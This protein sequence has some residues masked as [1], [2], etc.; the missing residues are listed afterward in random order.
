MDLYQQMK[1]LLQEMLLQLASLIHQGKDALMDSWRR[2]A[3]KVL[4][5]VPALGVCGCAV[6]DGA[7]RKHQRFFVWF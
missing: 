1:E 3:A 6:V 4:N 5:L 2:F 7:H